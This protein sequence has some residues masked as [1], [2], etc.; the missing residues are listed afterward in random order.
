ME[1]LAAYFPT[2]LKNLEQKV[3]L[4]EDALRSIA[5]FDREQPITLTILIAKTTLK[6]GRSL[7][8]NQDKKTSSGS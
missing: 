2:Y 5:Q 4:Y 7:N 8:E 6:E 3:R 1:K